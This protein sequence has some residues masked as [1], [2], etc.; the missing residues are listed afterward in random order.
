M[1]G[2]PEAIT[3]LNAALTGYFPNLPAVEGLRDIVV[4][5]CNTLSMTMRDSASPR[6]L[7]EIGHGQHC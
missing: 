2:Y 5:M 6:N 1:T 7:E 4:A 3:P